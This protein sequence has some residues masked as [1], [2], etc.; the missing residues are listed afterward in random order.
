MIEFYDWFARVTCVWLVCECVRFDSIDDWV[1]W[2]IC[3]CDVCVI[4]VWMCVIGVWMCKI[5]FDW[6]LILIIWFARV[7][8]VWLVCECVRFD[9]IEDWFLWLICAICACNVYVICVWCV[10]VCVTC[11]ID[12]CAMIHSHLWYDSI[13]V[14]FRTMGRS[15]MWHNSLRSVT[16]LVHMCDITRP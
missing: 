8:C 11:C 10:R 12:L 9:S 4:G 5:W 3:A 16:W 7:T 1:L 15:T 2:L 13:T 14:P 6:R